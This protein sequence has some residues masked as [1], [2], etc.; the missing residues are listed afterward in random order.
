M[1]IDFTWYENGDEQWVPPLVAIEHE[2]KPS[3]HER[4]RDYWKVNQIASTLRVF[5]GY[6]RVANEVE[7]AAE[8]LSCHEEKWHRVR[9]GESIIILGHGQMTTDFRAWSTPQG[10]RSWV[11]LPFVQELREHGMSA[12]RSLP[13]N[14]ESDGQELRDR[15]SERD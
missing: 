5:I 12:H 14:D 2:N 7:R 4:L 6:T 1:G 11:E 13:T 8:V 10:E 9:G 15:T 3:E